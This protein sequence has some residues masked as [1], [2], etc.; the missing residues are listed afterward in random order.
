MIRLKGRKKHY[1][2]IAASAQRTRAEIMYH[3]HKRNALMKELGERL[4]FGQTDGDIAHEAAV[5]DYGRGEIASIKEGTIKNL[6]FIKRW[7]L[8][9]IGLAWEVSQVRYAEVMGWIE[10]GICATL[11]EDNLQA[12]FQDISSGIP[13][14][15]S[16]CCCKRKRRR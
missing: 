12:M 4:D 11:S 9:D 10:S 13:Y 3:R 7:D 16:K 14:I 5:S 1:L 8:G 6:A 15:R 2:R